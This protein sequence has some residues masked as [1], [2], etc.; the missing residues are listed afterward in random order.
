[1]P[2][3]EALWRNKSEN[4]SAERESKKEKSE[5]QT[6]WSRYLECNESRPGGIAGWGSR[7][8]NRSLSNGVRRTN[9]QQSASKHDPSSCNGRTPLHHKNVE[10]FSSSLS[11]VHYF[12]ERCQDWRANAFSELGKP[13][14]HGSCERIA[15]GA[16]EEQGYCDQELGEGVFEAAV[17]DIVAVRKVD[18]EDGAEHDDDDAHGAHSGEDSEEDGQPA[19]KFGEADEVGDDERHVSE[20]CESVRAGTAERAEKDG[21]AVEEKGDAA[22]D[23]DGEKRGVDGWHGVLLSYSGVGGRGWRGETGMVG[24]RPDSLA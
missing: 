15:A 17:R 16:S 21:A 22:G 13:G 14:V 3:I 18:E 7:K 19:G 4:R 2:E 10:G 6:W 8:R 9:E 23:A 20:G 11:L 12:R 5:S 1:M 24:A